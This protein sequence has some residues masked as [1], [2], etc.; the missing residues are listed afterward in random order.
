L[1]TLAF[2]YSELTLDILE[3]L[4]SEIN[5]LTVVLLLLLQDRTGQTCVCGVCDK[6]KLLL[7]T[8]CKLKLVK[9][10]LPQC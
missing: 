1:Q 8:Q 6:S 2:L 4:L 3:A 7:E 9:S 5:A 10:L